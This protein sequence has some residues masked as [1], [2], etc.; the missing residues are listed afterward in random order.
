MVLEIEAAQDAGGW[1]WSPAS[2]GIGLAWCELLATKG[3]DIIPV[4]RR[5]DR[6]TAPKERLEADWAVSVSPLVVDLS[7]P[8]AAAAIS[9][10]LDRRGAA[11]DV[12]VNNAGFPLIDRFT[13]RTWPEQESF[14][15]VIGLSTSRRLDRYDVAGSSA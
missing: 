13:D 7:D 11:I 9:A 6:L 14:L 8:G 3:F 2:A 12:L 4:A 10:E 1:R 5:S 15:R